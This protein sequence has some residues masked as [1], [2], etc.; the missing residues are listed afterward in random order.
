MTQFITF[1]FDWGVSKEF[2]MTNIQNEQKEEE[3]KIDQAQDGWK[4][5]RCQG[6]E[7]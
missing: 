6:M 5:F 3:I 2:R 1:E 7:G 4:K